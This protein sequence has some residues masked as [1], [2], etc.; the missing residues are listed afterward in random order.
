MRNPGFNL[1]RLTADFYESLYSHFNQLEVHGKAHVPAQG[2]FLV[3]SNHAS[4]ADPPLCAA[5]FPRDHVPRYFARSTLFT[6]LWGRYLRAINAIPVDREADADVAAFRR[7]FDVI[8][9]GGSV[10]FYIEGTRTPDGRLQPAK[11]GMGLT[12]CRAKVPIVP[13][14]I[15]GSYELFGKGSPLP[16]LFTPVSITVG[17]PL[18]PAQLDPGKTDPERY[19]TVADRIMEAIAE[20]EPVREPRI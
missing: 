19:Q 3:A 5:I 14:R 12:A 13:M 8:K 11:K 10:V 2:P 4:F 16:S 1:Y 7:V 9:R 18:D 15:F 20:L 6:G 17:E